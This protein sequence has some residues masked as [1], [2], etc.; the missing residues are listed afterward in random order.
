MTL[1]TRFLKNITLG[2]DMR[3]LSIFSLGIAVGIMFVYGTVSLFTVQHDEPKTALPIN[4]VFEFPDPAPAIDFAEL[5]CLAKNIYFEARGEPLDGQVAVSQVVLNRV[6]SPNF[7]NDICGVIYQGPISDWF[8]QEHD[9]I[10]P[11]RHRCQFSWWCDGRS[12]EPRDMWAWGRAMTIAAAVLRGE[13]EDNT[14][15]AMWYHATSVDPN[16]QLQ[17]I[18]TIGNHLFYADYNYDNIQRN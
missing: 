14:N 16:W 13:T 15:G 8:L 10:V 4:I 7:P 18:G 9:R 12:D 5:E 3:K 1:I 2:D 6:N 11:L 17:Q